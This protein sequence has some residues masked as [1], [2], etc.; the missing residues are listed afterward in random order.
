MNCTTNAN[1]KQY[2]KFEVA[3]VEENYV[4]IEE[5]EYFEKLL[6]NGDYIRFLFL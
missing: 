3:L 6:V 4:F 5:F 2:I 1:F